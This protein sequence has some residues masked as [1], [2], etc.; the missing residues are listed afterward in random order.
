MLISKA[1]SRWQ[2]RQTAFDDA[3]ARYTHSHFYTTSLINFIII[4][5]FHI[6]VNSLLFFFVAIAVVSN[7]FIS[8]TTKK[9]LHVQ[10]KGDRSISCVFVSNQT[11]RFPVAMYSAQRMHC[12]FSIPIGRNCL[13]VCSVF[14]CLFFWQSKILPFPNKLI[15]KYIHFIGC[16]LKQLRGE[17]RRKHTHAHVLHI[18]CLCGIEMSSNVQNW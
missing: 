1:S 17:R 3:R 10:C 16:Q 13:S 15:I 11:F 8:K 7:V 12:F 6:I 5:P 9:C 2:N 18:L 4:A 14:A